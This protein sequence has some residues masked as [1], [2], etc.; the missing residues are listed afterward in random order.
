MGTLGLSGINA[1]HSPTSFWFSGVADTISPSQNNSDP[2]SGSHLQDYTLENSIRMG[3]AGLVLVAL[4]VL[5]YE[6]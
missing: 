5:L 6:A 2:T 4:G 1:S 3:M